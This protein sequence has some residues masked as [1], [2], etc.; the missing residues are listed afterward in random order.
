VNEYRAI[1]VMSGTSLDG[2]D[3]ACCFFTEQNGQWSY[4]IEQA[5]TIAYDNTFRNKL[6]NAGQLDGAALTLLSNEFGRKVGAEVNSF[7]EKHS[8]SPQLVASHG[9]TVFHQPGNKMTLQI[10]SGAEI[11][12]LTHITTVCDFRSKDVALGGQG[13]PLVP[14]GDKLLF[15]EYKYCLNLGGF[16]N[17]SFEAAGKRVSFDVCPVN[18][19]LNQLCQEAGKEFDENGEMGKKG[20]VNVALLQQLNDLAYYKKPFPKSLGKEWV[21]K[22]VMP[23][24]TKYDLPVQ[25]KLRTFYEHIAQQLAS[26]CKQENASLLLTG[27]GAHN[28]LLRQLIEQHCKVK[29]IVPAKQTIDFK[30]ALIFA[31]LGVLRIRE[32][33]N[34]LASV[35]GAST[36]SIGG[37]V[38]L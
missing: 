8:L 3:I 18:I 15:A 27:G 9:H 14:I 17:I 32:E 31:F 6:R 13:A 25:D 20:E 24:L 4:C 22:E 35:T 34:S 5:E 21:D 16:A 36:D 26:C 11:A 28:G 37:A 7:C 23:L 29:V 2:L 10:G 33:N 12:A 1:G 19:V 38:Y 30:E